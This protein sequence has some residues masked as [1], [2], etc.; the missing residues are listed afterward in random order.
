MPKIYRTKKG[1]E[2][3]SS[4]TDAEA[5]AWCAKIPNNNF[6]KDLAIKALQGLTLSEDQIAWAHVLANK[7]LDSITPQEGKI[8]RGFDFFRIAELFLFAKNKLK[9]PK[10]RL[11]GPEKELLVLSWAGE[12]SKYPETIPVVQW[13]GNYNTRFF[14]RIYQNGV[15]DTQNN[16]PEWVISVLREFSD[17]PVKVAAKYGKLTGKCCFCGLT[18]TD[19]RSTAVGYGPICANHYRLPWGE[20]ATEFKEGTFPSIKTDKD[21]IIRRRINLDYSLPPN[22]DKKN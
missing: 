2:V 22:E 15:F 13:L 19:D 21:T 7:Y 12:K 18:L 3:N 16:P 1:P 17:N 4:L 8:E 9:R 10:I 11:L 5:L 14:G 20:K 6:S